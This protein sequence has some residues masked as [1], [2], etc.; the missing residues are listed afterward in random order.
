MYGSEKVGTFRHSISAHQLRR[1]FYSLN[2]QGRWEEVASLRAEVAAQP[3]EHTE[4]EPAA[5]SE[6]KSKEEADLAAPAAS[7]AAS[8]PPP[9]SRAESV[10]VPVG[11]LGATLNKPF[12][13]C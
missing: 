9:I 4:E 6:T 10:V 13:A 12:A 8:F 1:W 5:S 3:R 2:K 7:Q 11:Q